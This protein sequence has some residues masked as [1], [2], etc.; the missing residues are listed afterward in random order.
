[1]QDALSSILVARDG[2]GDMAVSNALG[3]NVFDID[4]GLGLP[5]AISIAIRGGKPMMLLSDAEMVR[6]NKHKLQW[7]NYHHLSLPVFLI[8]LIISKVNPLLET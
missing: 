4:L 1:M 6:E 8:A 7:L 5:Y 3:S 2:Y